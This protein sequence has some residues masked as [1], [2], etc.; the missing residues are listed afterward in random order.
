MRIAKTVA[1]V[2]IATFGV[3]GCSHGVEGTYTTRLALRHGKG[4]SFALISGQ[5]TV[6]LE[7]GR[8][9]LA[10]LPSAASATPTYLSAP[11]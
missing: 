11:P 8:A 10:A 9:L 3:A 7:E 6:E 5:S 2:V 4:E 1:T